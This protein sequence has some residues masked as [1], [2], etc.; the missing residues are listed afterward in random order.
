MVSKWQPSG[1]G[2]QDWF[3]ELAKPALQGTDIEAANST[4]HTLL[5]VLDALLAAGPELDVFEAAATGQPL[6]DGADLHTPNGD[7]F[8]PLHLAARNGHKD[9]IR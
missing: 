1:L 3:V 6:P 5:Y 9:V 4:R 2:D 7:G 8:T